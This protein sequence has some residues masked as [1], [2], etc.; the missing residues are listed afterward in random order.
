MNRINT[1]HN[2]SLLSLLL[3]SVFRLL[4]LYDL[5]YFQYNNSQP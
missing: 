4:T 3:T 2:H 5:K 1:F